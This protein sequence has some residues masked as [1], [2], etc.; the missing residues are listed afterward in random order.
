MAEIRRISGQ[1]PHVLRPSAAPE[2][3]LPATPP[4]F[5]CRRHEP[6]TYYSPPHLDRHW[7]LSEPSAPKKGKQ[8]KRKKSERRE[9]NKEQRKGSKAIGKPH[10]LGKLASPSIT[11]FNSDHKATPWLKIAARRGPARVPE[12]TRVRATR[13]G[14]GNGRVGWAWLARGRTPNK[15]ARLPLPGATAGGASRLPA[16]PRSGDALAPGTLARALGRGEPPPRPRTAPLWDTAPSPASGRGRYK[17]RV[18]RPGTEPGVRKVKAEEK[19]EKPR[20]WRRTRQPAGSPPAVHPLP[21]APPPRQGRERGPAASQAL[22]RRKSGFAHKE[23]QYPHP[24]SAGDRPTR[25]GPPTPAQPESPSASSRGASSP[26]SPTAPCL[27]SWWILRRLGTAWLPRC[28]SVRRLCRQPA[29]PPT[30]GLAARLLSLQRCRHRRV[31][32]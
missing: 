4:P 29:R 20:G 28:P 30:G 22:P 24:A 31:P 13:H 25:S 9:E 21:S 11:Q 3:S 18:A 19:R 14:E 5:P 26:D 1:R 32:Q 10:D 17:G 2:K 27:S 15:A 23:Q 7:A 6:L 8:G 16:S 12:A